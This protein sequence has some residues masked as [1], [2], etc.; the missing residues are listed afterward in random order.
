MTGSLKVEEL[1][2]GYSI[3]DDK[4]SYD[5]RPNKSPE[6]CAVRLYED[7][8]YPLTMTWDDDIEISQS[9]MKAAVG[10]LG[11]EDM[12]TYGEIDSDESNCEYELVYDRKASSI[13]EAVAERQKTDYSGS[14]SMAKIV[15]TALFGNKTVDV[16]TVLAL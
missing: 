14:S 16:T 2:A 6:S 3:D 1:V 4:F 12:T 10:C 15:R 8:T 13:E 11:E 7:E 9:C 5:A